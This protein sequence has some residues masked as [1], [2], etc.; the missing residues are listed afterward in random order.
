MNLIAEAGS[1]ASDRAPPRAQAKHA[2]RVPDRVEKRDLLL[3]K[4]SH[5]LV[6]QWVTVRVPPCVRLNVRLKRVSY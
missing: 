5:A 6:Q 1:P 4:Q 2:F 3:G